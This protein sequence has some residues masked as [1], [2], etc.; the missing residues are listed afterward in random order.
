MICGYCDKTITTTIK[1]YFDERFFVK[2]SNK[3]IP[4]C[5]SE[6]ST[7]WMTREKYYDTKTSK[8]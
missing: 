2:N 6:C 4:F 8:P 5:N 3:Q 7:K 1:Y